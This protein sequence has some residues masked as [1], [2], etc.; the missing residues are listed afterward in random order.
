MGC[1]NVTYRVR[2]PSVWYVWPLLVH[3]HHLLHVLKAGI[4]GDHVVERRLVVFYDTCEAED[5]HFKPMFQPEHP[6][7]NLSLAAST[8]S[9]IKELSSPI[10]SERSVIMIVFTASR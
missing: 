9:F 7:L 6:C 2:K 10:V 5:F 1:V 4:A 8:A 3:A